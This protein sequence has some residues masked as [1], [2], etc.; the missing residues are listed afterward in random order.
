MGKSYLERH[1]LRMG[2]GGV[3][4]A[5]NPGTASDLIATLEAPAPQ[6]LVV[7]AVASSVVEPLV[8]E[9]PAG[10]PEVV[11]PAPTPEHD[12]AKR[13][14]GAKAEQRKLS[15][16]QV[17]LTTLKDQLDQRIKDADQ[18]DKDFAE[19]LTALEAAKMAPNKEALQEFLTDYPQMGTA[20]RAL[21]AE[22]LANAPALKRVETLDTRLNTSEENLTRAEHALKLQEV[23]G[24]V[25]ETYPD[26]VEIANSP[27]FH[28]F[29]AEQ[30]P[31]DQVEY[32]NAIYHRTSRTSPAKIVKIIREFKSSQPAVPV[33]PAAHVP[34]K[35]PKAPSLTPAPAG[36][37]EGSVTPLT[38]EQ[39]RTFSSLVTR[40]GTDKAARAALFAQLAAT[41]N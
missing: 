39:V 30:P 8:T 40:A 22:E 28:A 17:D 25:R 31:E 15:R 12:W 1:G 36:Q 6:E 13:E 27:A 11:V 35:A 2:A 18:R 23:I 21:I 24:K 10:Q 19:K 14:E 37:T 41:V 7:E 5:I 33:P 3:L 34:P 9:P 26:A 32:E 16:L 38:P 29:I 4:E 20:V